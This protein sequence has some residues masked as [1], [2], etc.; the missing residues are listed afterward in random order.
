MEGQQRISL[1]QWAP[2]PNQGRGGSREDCKFG[3]G[4]IEAE[5]PFRCRR[6]R[7]DIQRGMS[8]RGMFGGRKIE[9]AIQAETGRKLPKARVRHGEWTGCVCRTLLPMAG[10]TGGA[11]ERTGRIL[12]HARHAEGHFEEPGVVG[13]A[14][15][16]WKTRRRKMERL[17][18]P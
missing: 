18:R 16:S 4:P 6:E 2:R 8:W 12:G 7:L 15:S 11:A 17:L 14:G 13:G 5:A 3:L 10:E 9:T 1:R